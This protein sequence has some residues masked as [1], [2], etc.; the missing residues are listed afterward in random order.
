M[1]SE[2]CSIWRNPY[3]CDALLEISA[4]AEFEEMQTLGRVNKSLNV[5]MNDPTLLKTLI[6]F[7]KT[8]NPQDW[9]KYFGLDLS[10]DFKKAWKTLPDNIGEIFKT[11]CLEFADQIFWM[12]KGLNLDTYTKHLKLKFPELK[13]YFDALDSLGKI[14]TIESEWLIMSN[15]SFSIDL[16]SKLKVHNLGC[17][18]PKALEAIVCL[19]TKCIKEKT[20][21]IIPT[22]DHHIECQEDLYLVYLN[23][24]HETDF[25]K[26]KGYLCYRSIVD[27]LANSKYI[28]LEFTYRHFD[29]KT[30]GTIMRF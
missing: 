12:P 4:F 29:L 3:P 13:F 18:I 25:K 16:V 6:Y 28:S 17:S 14:S 9:N 5:S 11:R 24:N 27:R 15:K 23:S 19:S 1:I 7:K 21:W 2:A 10:A 8:F 20:P 26:M 22:F 30:T